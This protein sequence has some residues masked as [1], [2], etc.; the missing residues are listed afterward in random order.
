MFN[1]V[2]TYF[3]NSFGAPRNFIGAPFELTSKKISS[4]MAR[5]RSLLG[6]WLSAL[7]AGFMKMFVE[8]YEQFE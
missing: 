6:G 2:N 5:P 7:C 4:A 3:E 8:S 1:N